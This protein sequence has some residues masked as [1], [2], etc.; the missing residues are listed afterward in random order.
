WKRDFLIKWKTIRS[1]GYGL[2]RHNKR[3]VIADG[4][5]Y[6]RIVGFYLHQCDLE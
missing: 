6:V 5:I 2:R 4:G 3:R 1:S